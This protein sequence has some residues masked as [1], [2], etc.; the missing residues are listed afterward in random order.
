MYSAYERHDSCALDAVYAVH[1]YPMH[2]FLRSER[3][4][5]VFGCQINN[6]LL[7]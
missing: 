4:L 6:S 7:A 5:G 2:A 3:H 1:A